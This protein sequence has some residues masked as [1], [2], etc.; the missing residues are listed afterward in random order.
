VS[1]SFTSPSSSHLEHFT[2]PELLEESTAEVMEQTAQVA[3]TAEFSGSAV[4]DE[5]QAEPVIECHEPAAES[6]DKREAPVLSDSVIENAMV[7]E[8]VAVLEEPVAILE[9][10]IAVLEE[11]VAVFDEPAAAVPEETGAMHDEAGAEHA[12]F[13]CTSEAPVL[14]DEPIEIPAIEEPAAVLA[15]PIAEAADL[16]S[17]EAAA[18]AHTVANE[19][20]EI[21]D[22]AAQVDEA[23]SF[24]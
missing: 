20:T 1:A 19:V 13:E 11:P 10:P 5:T 14:T 22:Q 17:D 21:H 16:C 24:V 3:D 2:M 18:E 23:A 4:A 12:A 7:D 8:S 9:E 6:I 15:E